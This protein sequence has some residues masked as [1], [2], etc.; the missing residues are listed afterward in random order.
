MELQFSFPLV[1]FSKSVTLVWKARSRAHWRMKSLLYRKRLQILQREWKVANCAHSGTGQPY[2]MIW[3]ACF[4]IQ[5]CPA[6]TK[7]NIMHQG[8]VNV[9]QILRLRDCTQDGIASGE[10]FQVTLGNQSTMS[11]LCKALAVK[12]TQVERVYE[13]GT[14]LW[15]LGS[16]ITSVYG[17]SEI[18]VG[19]SRPVLLS[20]RTPKLLQWNLK[21]YNP[22]KRTLKGGLIISVYYMGKGFRWLQVQ[23]DL[24][25]RGWCQT[26]LGWQL[27]SH[28]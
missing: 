24:M 13:E 21:K 18:T 4:A 16:D 3:I 15:E 8:T 27:C 28:L 20:R 23:H 14:F 26:K 6:S 22:S 2:S 10:D 1:T 7:C 5:M 19:Q 17:I 9:G 12:N 25:A 11:S